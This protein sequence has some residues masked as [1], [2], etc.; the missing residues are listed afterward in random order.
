MNPAHIAVIIPISGVAF[1]ATARETDNGIDIRETVMPDLK[2]FLIL[3]I[4]V[5]ISFLY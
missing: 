4:T 2:L 5:F 1:D 3:L